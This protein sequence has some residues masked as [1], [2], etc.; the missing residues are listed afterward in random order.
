MHVLFVVNNFPFDGRPSDGIFN[1]RQL[2]AMRTRGITVSVVRIA[3]AGAWLSES[4]RQYR[5]LPD[6]YSVDG[7]PVRVLWG[8]LGPRNIGMRLLPMQLGSA[9]RKHAVTLD[10]DLVHAHGLIPAGLVAGAVDAPLV[11]TAHGSEAYRLPWMRSELETAA[12]TALRRADAAAA[13][14]EFVGGH[15]RRLGAENVRI[16][17]NGADSIAFAPRS[18]EL[19]RERLGLDAQTPVIAFAGHLMAEKGVN[20]LL[21]ATARLRELAPVLMMAGTGSLAPSI[22]ARAREEGI[23]VQLCGQLTHAQLA[24]VFAAADVVTLPSYAEG[25]PAAV[26]EAMMS[27]RAVVASAVGGIPEIVRDGTSGYVVPPRDADALAGALGR[28]L[29]DRALRE[30]FEGNAHAF[31]RE[32]LTWDANADAYLSLYEELMLQKHKRSRLRE[33]VTALN[34][35]DLFTG[36]R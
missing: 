24:D 32:H 23:N 28:V 7:I 21:D 5:T 33:G 8:L 12:A 36:R 9:L 31:A 25:L 2:Q 20:E 34:T 6:A 17:H 18:R 11:V 35:R 13:V 15:L 4:R 3:P 22:T 14:S 1:L 10:I 16:I 27:G 19:A 30:T 26:C 29:R